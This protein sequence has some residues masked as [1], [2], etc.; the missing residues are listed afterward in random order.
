MR[1]KTG[2]I[3][4]YFSVILACQPNIDKSPNAQLPFYDLSGLVAQIV[5][6]SQIVTV[7]K[8]I[9]IDAEPEIKKIVDYPLWKDVKEFAYYDI[10]RPALFDKY[11][12]DTIS[13]NGTKAL[14]YRP[15]EDHLK[16]RLLKVFLDGQEVKRV[17]INSMFNSF[18][19][20][21]ALNIDWMIGEG[22]Q[23]DRSSD[24]LFGNTTTQIIKVEID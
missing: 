1:K 20:D 13:E 3:I 2:L 12:G 7:E 6:D 24:K 17:V 9:T 11:Q 15:L 22:Y 8:S 16:V 21:V 19:E 5:S 4:F 14:V 23:I 10:N 18:L